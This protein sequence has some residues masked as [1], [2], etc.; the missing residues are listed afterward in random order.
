MRSGALTT[1]ARSICHPDFLSAG[2]IFIRND[3]PLPG[4][5]RFPYQEC[6]GWKQLFDAD[7]FTLERSARAAGW[8]FASIASPLTGRGW[9]ATPQ[10]ALRR[11]LGKIMG[12]VNRAGFN[13]FEI[14]G[15]QVRG[16]RFLGSVRI[17]AIPRYFG[18]SPFLKNLDPHDY[19]RV[20]VDQAEEI[21]W[22][23]SEVEPT[24]KGI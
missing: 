18:Q 14:R 13:S 24:I 20:F 8:H 12:M 16:F 21:Y 2:G 10:S 4:W 6:V 7:G 19:P 15:I 9:G 23:A 1:E 3:V 11:A 5:F 22:R 17:T